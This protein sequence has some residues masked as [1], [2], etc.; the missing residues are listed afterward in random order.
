MRALALS[1]LAI[2]MIG[3][4]FVGCSTTEPKVTAGSAT[5]S[6]AVFEDAFNDAPDD[7]VDEM[8]E[9]DTLDQD[10]NIQ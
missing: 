3:A 1:I 2:I 10:L 5:E 9:L 8:S 4:L 6:E 7:T